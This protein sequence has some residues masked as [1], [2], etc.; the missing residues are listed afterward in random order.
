MLY[1]LLHMMLM[2]STKSKMQLKKTFSTKN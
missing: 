1:D 2:M